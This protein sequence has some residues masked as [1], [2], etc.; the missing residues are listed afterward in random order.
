MNK[1]MSDYC[2]LSYLRVRTLLNFP[3]AENI[4]KEI[5]EDPLSEATVVYLTNPCEFTENI[6]ALQATA[7]KRLNHLYNFTVTK[8]G[9]DDNAPASPYDA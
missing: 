9:K 6:Q 3:G 4:L 8:A 2:K 7:N 1:L 5:S